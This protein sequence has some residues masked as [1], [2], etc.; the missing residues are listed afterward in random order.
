MAQETL[1]RIPGPVLLAYMIAFLA[2]ASALGF[3]RNAIPEELPTIP[4]I[5]VG[6]Y[7]GSGRNALASTLLP[8]I[9]YNCRRS[10]G[11][12]EGGLLKC[13]CS[14]CLGNSDPFYYQR[15]AAVNQLT[16][17]GWGTDSLAALILNQ[18]YSIR[19]ELNHVESNEL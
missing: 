19:K 18:V 5:G 15:V 13:I 16:E 1:S 3:T 8:A 14:K 9:C 6:P 7:K 4:S 12:L 2:P 17:D 10:V 11:S